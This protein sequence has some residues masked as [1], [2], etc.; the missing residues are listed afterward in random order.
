MKLVIMVTLL[1][2]GENPT[3]P[4]LSMGSCQEMMIW[5]AHKEKFQYYPAT[6]HLLLF[7][8]PSSQGPGVTPY[9]KFPSAKTSAQTSKCPCKE[10]CKFG[11]I[12]YVKYLSPITWHDVIVTCQSKKPKSTKPIMFSEIWWLTNKNRDFHQ[13]GVKVRENTMVMSKH[14]TANRGVHTP[15]SANHRLHCKTLQLA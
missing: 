2:A 14:V 12:W 6:L 9:L 13:Q 1:S 5:I 15:P 8:L 10:R 4:C 11:R 3:R 7:A